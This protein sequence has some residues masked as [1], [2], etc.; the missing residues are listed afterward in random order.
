MVL[1]R[2]APEQLAIGGRDKLALLRYQTQELANDL[3]QRV[4][5]KTEEIDGDVD[6]VEEE[7][8]FLLTDLDGLLASAQEQRT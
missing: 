1:T 6:A 8:E 3:R 4:R 5:S 2:T 7:L